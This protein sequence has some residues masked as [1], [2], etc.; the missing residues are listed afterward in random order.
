MYEAI[1]GTV[2]V[3]TH[4][5]VSMLIN[6]QLNWFIAKYRS[7]RTSGS[8][9]NRIAWMLDEWRLNLA[10][11]DKISINEF[12]EEI[13][14]LITIIDKYVLPEAGVGYLSVE[15]DADLRK[16]LDNLTEIFSK[17][18]EEFHISN[19][20]PVPAMLML[21]SPRLTVRRYDL[22]TCP[23]CGKPVHNLR[24]INR[25]YCFNCKTYI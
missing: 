23:K 15:E 5:I 14:K 9:L 8:T 13:R 7:T 11:K 20:I 21:K 4:R 19:F 10:R 22:L 12:A 3:D 25:L 2:V 24:L 18:D 6:P 16:L 1:R 17:F